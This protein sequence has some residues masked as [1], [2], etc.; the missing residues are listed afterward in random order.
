M[1]AMKSLVIFG[2]V[3]A[4][5]A[6][7]RIGPVAAETAILMNDDA[8]E[9]DIARALRLARPDC[10]APAGT[11]V[12][13]PTSL[14]RGLRMGDINQMTTVLPAVPPSSAAGPKQVAALP[15]HEYTAAFR[16]NFEYGSA[17]LTGSARQLLDRIGGVM[18]APG[19]EVATFRITGHTDGVGSP[20]RNQRLSEQRA[21]AV[22]LYF[23]GRYHIEPSRLYATGKGAGD[24]LNPGNPAAPENRRVEI[25]NLVN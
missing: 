5:L 3:G 23:V 13:F 6:V 12:A 1:R 21:N 17:R 25:T 18:S 15:P 19:A 2:A 14:T 16:V 7:S 11:V 8:S 22:R 4:A 20:T 24:L 9:C 10:P